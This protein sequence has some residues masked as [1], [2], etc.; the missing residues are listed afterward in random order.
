MSWGLADCF[1]D[2]TF[3]YEVSEGVSFPP[4]L[5]RITSLD[6]SNNPKTRRVYSLTF[7]V[8]KKRRRR[9]RTYNKGDL[10]FKETIVTYYL[11]EQKMNY[12]DR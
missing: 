11:Q 9:K 4:R 7:V 6:L 2:I 12:C 3:S 10:L 1:R 8:E 5:L